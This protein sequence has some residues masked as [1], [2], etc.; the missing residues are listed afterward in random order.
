MC[1]EYRETPEG[2]EKHRAF[3]EAF[4]TEIL[5]GKTERSNIK[6]RFVID[7]MAK[8]Y[9]HWASD[10]CFEKPEVKKAYKELK[11]AEYAYIKSQETES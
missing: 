1:S 6:G 9:L 7:T 5:K 4:D 3:N 2:Q 11:K 8:R 10:Q